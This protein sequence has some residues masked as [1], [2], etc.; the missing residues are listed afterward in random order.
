MFRHRWIIIL[1]CI[2][3]GINFRIASAQNDLPEP[4]NPSTIFA[5]NLEISDGSRLFWW[6]SDHIYIYERQNQRW[7]IYPIPADVPSPDEYTEF[8]EL[9]DGRYSVFFGYY[10]EG[11]SY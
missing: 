11:E 9:D 5:D 3:V 4:V 10:D 8:D 2:A 6:D 1:L 7:H